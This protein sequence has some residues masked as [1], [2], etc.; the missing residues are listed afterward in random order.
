MLNTR[1]AATGAQVWQHE[2][3]RCTSSHKKVRQSIVLPECLFHITRLYGQRA[4]PPR[5]KPQVLTLIALG[6]GEQPDTWVGSDKDDGYVRPFCQ[7][8]RSPE[9]SSSA[10]G[11]EVTLCEANPEDS[12]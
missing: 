2:E 1:P 8:R 10:V 7:G 6:G 5:A 11:L 9:Q 4:R 12:S 3:P